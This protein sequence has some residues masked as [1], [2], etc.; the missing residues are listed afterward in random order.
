MFSQLIYLIAHR[1]YELDRKPLRKTIAQWFFMT[2]LPSRYTRN[3]ENPVEQD[4]RHIAESKFG[5][6]FV[7]TLDEIID[8][9]LTT[10]YWTIQIPS[11]LKTSS[12]YVPTVL[13]YHASLVRP[14]AQPP[15]SPIQLGELPDPSTHA[16][17][18]AV[19]YHHL[20]PKAYLTRISIN[21]TVQRNQIAN[22][23][24]VEGPDNVK[25]GNL[26]SNEYSPL[27]FK[28]LTPRL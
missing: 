15:F 20:F 28:E 23:A 1:D 12:A 4:L 18:S 14:N 24:F 6:K 26:P 17:R 3:F 2:S 21:H 22:Y 11:S 10:D 16:T 7:T 25:I 13:G 19:R 9:A 27:L 5:Y 8:T